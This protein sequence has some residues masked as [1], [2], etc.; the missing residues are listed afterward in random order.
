[1]CLDR[2]SPREIPESKGAGYPFWA[3]QSDYLVFQKSGQNG[4]QVLKAAASGSTGLVL[5]TNGGG[6]LRAG[7]WGP[8]GTIIIAHAA[9]GKRGT[10]LSGSARG[11]PLSRYLIFI[12]IQP[13]PNW[14]GLD[15]RMFYPYM[16]I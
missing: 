15:I 3:P 10:L 11:G 5:T 8:N 1:M 4:R 16:G 13:S 6:V 14:S 12:L 9:S 7:T 2:L